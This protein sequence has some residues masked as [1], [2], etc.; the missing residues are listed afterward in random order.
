MGVPRGPSLPHGREGTSSAQDGEGGM[1][2]G[3]L[4]RSIELG[5]RSPPLLPGGD[6][7]R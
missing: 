6:Q 4:Q 3:E 1:E 2:K 5:C 7:R